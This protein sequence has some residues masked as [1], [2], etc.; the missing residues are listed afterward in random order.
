MK[1]KDIK[2][3]KVRKALIKRALGYDA[4]EVVEEYVKTE[5]GVVLS[6][7][8]V[9]IKNVPPDISAL[10]ILIETQGED[11]TSLTSEQLEREKERL[12]LELNEKQKKEN[13][14]CKK[15]TKKKGQEKDL[16][17]S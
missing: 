4:E 2:E 10:K 11:I 7:K 3:K 17:K 12:L 14:K 5:E 8:K 6:K 1:E 9:T 15:T 13:K 16:S